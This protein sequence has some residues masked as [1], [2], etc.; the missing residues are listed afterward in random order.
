MN[1]SSF[2]IYIST[3]LLSSKILLTNFVLKEMER[4]NIS[5]FIVLYKNNSIKYFVYEKKILFES[6]KI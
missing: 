1:I 4:N 3:K 5:K 2:F 6:K